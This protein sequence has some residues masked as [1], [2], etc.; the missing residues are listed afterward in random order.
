MPSLEKLILVN[1]HNLTAKDIS[2]AILSRPSRQQAPLSIAITRCRKISN[3]DMMFLSSQRHIKLFMM[4]EKI[5]NEPRCY[6]LELMQHQKTWIR[7][8]GK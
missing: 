8:R 7:Y 6:D 1:C 5:N 4:G 3:D 2:F